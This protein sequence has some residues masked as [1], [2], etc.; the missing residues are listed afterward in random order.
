MKILVFSD[1]HKS[2]S[3]MRS[4]MGAVKPDAVIH[5]GDHYDDGMAIAEEYPHIRFYQVP[6]NCDGL[7][8]LS[9]EPEVMNCDVYGVRIFMTHGHKQSV[10]SGIHRLLLEARKGNAKAVLFG[11]THEAVCYVEEDGLL[12]MNPGSCGEKNKSAGLLEI[13]DKKISSYRILRQE[14]I[15]TM[16]AEK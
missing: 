9:Q 1:S 3:F 5:L 8:I 13:E 14:D 7:R 4:C 11:H 16:S 10:K 15:D 6:G 12:V 2:L